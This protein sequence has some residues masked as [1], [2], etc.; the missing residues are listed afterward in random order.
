V[1]SALK[2]R[3]GNALEMAEPSGCTARGLQTPASL[4]PST[5]ESQV[6]QGIRSLP[7]TS[8]DVVWTSVSDGAVLFSVSR[9]LYYG[10]NQV[11]AFV[12]QQLESENATLDDLCDAVRQ[13]FPDAPAE[14]IQNDVREL[15]DDFER[16]GLVVAS[17]A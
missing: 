3:L 17:A 9:E 5:L 15:L 11:A 6:S 2:W 14:E 4:P 10:A 7:R 13:R 12:W 1:T 8:P 16:H